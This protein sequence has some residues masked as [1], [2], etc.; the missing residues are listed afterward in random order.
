MLIRQPH[1]E[2]EMETTQAVLQQIKALESEMAQT[3]AAEMEMIH[4]VLQQIKALESEKAQTQALVA[5][6]QSLLLE[7]RRG[8]YSKLNS[9][10][11]VD[12]LPVEIKTEIFYNTLPV[13]PTPKYCK[14]K[15][16]EMHPFFLG[17]ICRGWRQFVWSTPVLWTILHLWLSVDR[18]D[19]QTELLREWLSRT[20]ERIY[21][22]QHTPRMGN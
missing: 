3:Q 13:H 14:D 17:K 18:Y 19:T 12:K 2:A 9:L 10:S 5:Q 7:Q 11:P 21:Q 8:L 20:A 22:Q 4:A 16:T 6:K 15:G 1:A